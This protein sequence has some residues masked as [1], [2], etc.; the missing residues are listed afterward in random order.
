M[1]I[2]SAGE[3]RRR[4]NQSPGLQCSVS[5]PLRNQPTES[6]QNNAH[7]SLDNGDFVICKC[8]AFMQTDHNPDITDDLK[9]SSRIQ[10]TKAARKNQQ[11]QVWVRLTP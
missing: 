3:R 6:V 1:D 9:L 8:K 2:Q 7:T 11:V 10:W 4:F 5:V